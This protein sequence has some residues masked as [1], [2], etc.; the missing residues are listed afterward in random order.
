MPRGVDYRIPLADLCSGCSAGLHGAHNP[1][2]CRCAICSPQ[3]A[4]RSGWDCGCSPE[5]RKPKSN[6]TCATCGGWLP[7]ERPPSLTAMWR[8]EAR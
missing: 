2:A 3:L 6:G 1:G 4:R 8:G 5:W 7:G